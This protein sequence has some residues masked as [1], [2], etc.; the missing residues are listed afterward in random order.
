M[1]TCEQ[2]NAEPINAEPSATKLTSHFVTPQS[3][4]YRRNHGDFLDEGDKDPEDWQLYF[5]VDEEVAQK[6]PNVSPESEL[7]LSQLKSQWPVQSVLAAMECAGNRRREMAKE[8]SETQPEGLQW[9][10]AA[11]ANLEWHGVRLRSLLLSLGVPDPY[12]H[13]LAEDASKLVPREVSFRE[14]AQKWSQDLHVHFISSQ[15]L[16]DDD[17]KGSVQDEHYGSSVSLATALHP[18]SDVLLAYAANSP[19]ETLQ[20]SHGYPLRVV[21]PGHLG[22]RWTKWLKCIRISRRPNLSE[23]MTLDYKILVP[24]PGGQASQQEW[25]ESMT[26]DDADSEKRKKELLRQPPMMMLGVGAGISRPESDQLIDLAQCKGPDGS[27]RLCVEGYAVG[28]EGS[29]VSRIE[30]AVVEGKEDSDDAQVR[31]A[32]AEANSW[33]TLASGETGEQNQ[34]LTGRLQGPGQDARW[35]SWSWTLWEAH[36][37]VDPQMRSLSLVVR[38]CEFWRVR[39]SCSSGN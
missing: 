1:H 11:V 22:A 3:D 4:L 12:G 32:A 7:S 10:Q 21:I 18:N 37:P 23:P 31:A 5:L 16:E 19:N 33:H 26:G 25:I 30:V 13:L 15:K 27:Y 36:V 38:A 8:S 28:T 6:W 34:T 14:D 24:P 17:K 35:P 2:S 9:Q 20:A 29:P 39:Y